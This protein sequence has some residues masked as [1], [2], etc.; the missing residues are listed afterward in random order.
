ML[1]TLASNNIYVFPSPQGYTHHVVYAPLA[2]SAFI[3]SDEDL[4]QLCK[5]VRHD[6][7]ADEEYRAI[8][9]SLTEVTTPDQRPGRAFGARA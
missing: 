8:A 9:E 5:A 3:A 2:D 6:T 7:D 1:Q 4:V